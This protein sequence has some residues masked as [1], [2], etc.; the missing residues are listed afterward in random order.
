MSDDEFIGFLKGN[1][2]KYLHRYKH[3]N[4]LDD[5]IK[6]KDY[7]DR[8]IKKVETIPVGYQLY[9]PSIDFHDD[10]TPHYS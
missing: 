2:I 6:G 9:I 3:K 7:Y 5:L 10:N 8:L 4:G 1:V